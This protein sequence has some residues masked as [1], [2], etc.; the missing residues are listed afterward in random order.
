MQAQG[1]TGRRFPQVKEEA[2]G[3]GT[4]RELPTRPSR[5]TKQAGQKAQATC[6]KFSYPPRTAT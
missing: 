1:G 2:E 6:S 4:R 3:R 5:P